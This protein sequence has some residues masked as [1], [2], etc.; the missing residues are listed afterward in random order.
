MILPIVHHTAYSAPQPP[1]GRF[2]MGKFARLAEILVAEGLAPNGFHE[3]ALASPGDLARAHDA[4]YV[5][6]VLE[7][8]LSP[9]Q[10]RQIGLKMSPELALRSRAACGGTMLTARLALAHGLACN[11]AGGSHHAGPDGGAGFCV[12]NDVAVAALALL[13]EG[14]IR[15]ALVIDLDVHQG[16]GT[17]RIFQNDRRVFTFS[18]HCEDN[19]PHRKARS[20]L[21]LNL[22]AGMGDQAYLASVIPL[23]PRLFEQVTPDLVFY[24]AGA[25][26]HR[27]DALGRLDLT[28]EGLAAR[29]RAVIRSVRNAGM[30]LAC[31]L[32]GGYGDVDAVAK[33]HAIL[34]RSAARFLAETETR[35]HAGQRD[36]ACPLDQKPATT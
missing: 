30:A 34:H 33:R 8:S 36:G 32:G 11:T 4:A 18:A 29:D 14:A 25:D 22:P 35:R 15:R 20:D 6:A 17:A 19:Y 3:P 2:P 10:E 27:D 24:I 21:D 31:V 7:Q 16:D 12:F 28:D 5:Q 9:A 26:P 13:A 1:G 23:L